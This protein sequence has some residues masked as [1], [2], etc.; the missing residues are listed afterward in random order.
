MVL[1]NGIV[2]RGVN[3]RTAL[4]DVRL[5]V[6]QVVWTNGPLV[7]LMAGV[8]LP[9]GDAK[10]GFGNGSFDASTALLADFHFSGYY[11]GTTNFGVTVPG[12]YRGYQIVGLRP[13]W[14]AGFSLEA[15]WW[16]R[17]SIIVQTLAQG[18]PLPS[19]GIRQMDWPGVLLTIGCRYYGASGNIEFSLTEDPDTAGAP[20][21][22]A[23]IGYAKRF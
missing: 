17:F 19:T 21:F 22:I 9:T 12:N 13:F 8:E 10:T 5:T 11:Q 14:H 4:A 15:A 2:V 18:T 7:S 20:D 6:K 23:T 1:N 3:D 16:H